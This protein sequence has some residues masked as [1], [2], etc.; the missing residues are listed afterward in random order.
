MRR[1]AL[2]VSRVAFGDNNPFEIVV[3]DGIMRKKT[4]KPGK[5]RKYAEKD[6]QKRT[7]QDIYDHRRTFGHLRLKKSFHRAPWK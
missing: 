3:I 4:E 5:R 1:S 2:P 7:K 6:G